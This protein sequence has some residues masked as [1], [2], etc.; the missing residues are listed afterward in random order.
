M[1]RASDDPA[2][3]GA[4]ASGVQWRSAGADAAVGVWVI[5]GTALVVIG[6]VVA[7]EVW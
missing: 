5:D 4:V 3:A 7:G 6:Q 1:R 2:A